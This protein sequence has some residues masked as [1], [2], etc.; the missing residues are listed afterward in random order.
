M[1]RPVCTADDGGFLSRR[2]AKKNNSKRSTILQHLLAEPHQQML[3]NSSALEI[4]RQRGEAAMQRMRDRCRDGGGI[5]E[6]QP[7]TY[8]IWERKKS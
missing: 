5:G 7:E 1:C 4:K 8:C 2:S 3:Q 6:K